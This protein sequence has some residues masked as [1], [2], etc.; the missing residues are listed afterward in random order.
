VAY[1]ISVDPGGVHCGVACWVRAD[2]LWECRWA[3]EMTPEACVDYV[4]DAINSDD[5][6]EQT[7]CEGFWLKPGMDALR[8][9]GSQMETCEVIGVVVHSCRWAGVPCIKVANGQQSIITRLEAV[10]YRWVSR[11]HGKHAKDAEAIGVRGLGLRVRQLKQIAD[12]RA[13]GQ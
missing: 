10:D 7:I 9:A 1:V 3:V 12:A 11:G 5:P 4:R 6:P 2:D 8:Q 13:A